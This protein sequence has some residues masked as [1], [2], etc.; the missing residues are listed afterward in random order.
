MKLRRLA[1]YFSRLQT[2]CLLFSLLFCIK[3]T[4]PYSVVPFIHHLQQD[5]H[6][7]APLLQ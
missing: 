6:L 1:G 5:M 4:P 3:G 7:L 2:L